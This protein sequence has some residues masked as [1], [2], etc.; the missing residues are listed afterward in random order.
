MGA[1]AGG[2]G[3]L[4]FS[5]PDEVPAAGNSAPSLTDESNYDERFITHPSQELPPFV[6]ERLMPVVVETLT[7]PDTVS[8]D[9]SLHEPHKVY[10]IKRQAELVTRPKGLTVKP[11]KQSTKQETIQ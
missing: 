2:L 1:L 10:R 5:T 8:E 3:T 4:L 6:R 9:G 11:D 7:E